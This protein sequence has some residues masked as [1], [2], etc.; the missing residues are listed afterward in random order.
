MLQVNVTADSFIYNVRDALLQKD[1]SSTFMF[2]EDVDDDVWTNSIVEV[3][4]F[5]DQRRNEASESEL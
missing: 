3:N 4:A 2:D 1:F 5:Y